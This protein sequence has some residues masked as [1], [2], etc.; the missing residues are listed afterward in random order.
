VAKVA[1]DMLWGVLVAETALG[2][3][4]PINCRLVVES[5]RCIRS[6]CDYVVADGI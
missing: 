3:C 1:S 2:V 4:M 5:V 6:L